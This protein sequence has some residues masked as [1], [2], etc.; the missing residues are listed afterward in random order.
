MAD[1]KAATKG[2]KKVA[3]FTAEERGASP[4]DPNGCYT[5]PR[6]AGRTPNIAFSV[7]PRPH[8]VGLTAKPTGAFSALSY[9]VLFNVRTNVGFTP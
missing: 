1:Q 9:T 3:K 5:I 8:R 6:T 4:S 2:T 7:N